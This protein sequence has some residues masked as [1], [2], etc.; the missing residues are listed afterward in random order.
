MTRN[1]AINAYIDKFGHINV[2]LATMPDATLLPLIENALQTEK[3]IPTE[4]KPG[5]IY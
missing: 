2:C 4:Y 1:E 3:E 5:C